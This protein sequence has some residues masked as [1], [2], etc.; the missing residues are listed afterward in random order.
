LSSILAFS[1]RSKF[2]LENASEA[3]KVSEKKA[4]KT[5]FMR[6]KMETTSQSGMGQTGQSIM[7]L[8]GFNI[9]LKPSPPLNSATAMA[10]RL[11]QGRRQSKVLLGRIF[12]GFFH[13]LVVEIV[14]PA[15][16]EPHSLGYLTP[17]S[18]RDGLIAD[19]SGRG[20]PLG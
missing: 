13:K 2:G 5:R 10:F 16:L 1:A 9:L 14:G 6:S 18:V 12:V 15:I 4:A 17:P 3:K 8:R 7:Q 19:Q 20:F 11:F